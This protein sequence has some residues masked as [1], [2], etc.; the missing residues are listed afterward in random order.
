MSDIPFHYVDLRTFCYDTEDEQRVERALRH[1]LPADD[2]EIERA[3]SEG[4]HGDRIVVFSVRVERASEI[5]HVFD[6]LKAGAD[7]DAIRDQLEDRVTEN[8]EFFVH[9]DKQAAYQGEAELG[10]GISFRAKVEAYPAK[11]DAALE[12]AR[13]ALA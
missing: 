10:E 12:N 4:H 2:I 9:L 5:R 13:N 3:E 11:R 8:C 6:Q 7:I 1:F